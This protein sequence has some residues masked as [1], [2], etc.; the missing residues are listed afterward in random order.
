LPDLQPTAEQ[1]RGAARR[2]SRPYAIT[3]R[4]RLREKKF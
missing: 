4:E 1:V 3:Q 2:R